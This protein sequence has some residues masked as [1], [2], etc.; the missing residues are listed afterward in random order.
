MSV[1]TSIRLN[2]S[3]Q[4]GVSRFYAEILCIRDI[5]R[6]PPP[7]LFLLDEVVGGT[8]WP[9]RRIGAEA[10]VRRLVARGAIDLA[11]THDLALVQIAEELAQR[12][13]KNCPDIVTCPL[14][15]SP[16]TS[17]LLVPAGRMLSKPMKEESP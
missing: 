8:N 10:I 17:S 12:A 13:A 7:L 5:L 14:S 9:G 6:M 11:P 15:F 16:Q 4:E 3:L 2:D 1:G